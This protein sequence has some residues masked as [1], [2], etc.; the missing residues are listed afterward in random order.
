MGIT[1]GRQNLKTLYIMQILLEQTDEGHSLNATD[2]REI[3]EREY[4]IE[5]HRQTIY[6]E[7]AKLMDF[8]LDIIQK[9]GEK[10]GGYYLASRQFELPELKLLVDAVQSSRFI[11]E[12]KSKELIGKLE[13]LCSKE[14]ARQISNQVIIYNRSKTVNET[15]YYNVDMLHSA[16]YHNRRITCRYVE[17]TVG[18]KTEYRHGGAFYELSPLHLVWDDEN[19]YLIAYDEQAEKVKHYRVDKMRD[20]SILDMR[21]SEKAAEQQIDLAAFEKKTFGMFGGE[22]EKVRLVCKNRLAGVI[23]DRFGTDI[24]MVP[25]D[26]EHFTASVTVTVSPQ[27]FGWVTAIGED[28]KIDSPETVKKQYQEYLQRILQ[29][30][31]SVISQGEE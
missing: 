15:I 10:L 23:L 25:A 5:V 7:I 21:Q 11:T 27:F 1:P 14:E 30:Y 16:I 20:M 12:K 13:T 22:D 29:G 26:K 18:K 3:L 2:I 19:Y 4:D 31:S 9:E 17:W 8:G 24:F 28:M 6:S